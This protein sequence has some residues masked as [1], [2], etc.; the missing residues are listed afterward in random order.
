[1][2]ARL[3]IVKVSGSSET[4]SRAASLSIKVAVMVRPGTLRRSLCDRFAIFEHATGRP[5]R[6]QLHTPEHAGRT[7]F[8]RSWCAASSH[9]SPHP[10]RTYGV[11]ENPP[12]P[13]FLCE[14]ARHRGERGLARAVTGGGFFGQ[15]LNRFGFSRV[16]DFRLRSWRCRVGISHAGQHVPALGCER[17][18]DFASD[19]AARS[20]NQRRGSH[21]RSSTLIARRSSIAR[22]PSATW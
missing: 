9:V 5:T 18:S 13:Q 1:S 21:G 22:Y 15:A 10:S 12:W 3:I 8:H 2:N 11:Y 14:Q 20:R 7:L 19:A 6:R 16:D 17:A 4:K